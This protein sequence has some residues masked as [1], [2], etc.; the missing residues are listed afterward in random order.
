METI[1]L[2]STNG[3]RQSSSSSSSSANEFKDLCYLLTC[4][5]IHE[6]EAF[7]SLWQ[8]S[9]TQ[10]RESLAKQLEATVEFETTTFGSACFVIF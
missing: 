5:S 2:K 6:V 9:L 8:G 10:A 4:K 1:I 3:R 7:Q